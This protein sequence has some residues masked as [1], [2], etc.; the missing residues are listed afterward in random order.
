MGCSSSKA[1]QESSIE[2]KPALVEGAPK[3]A[4]PEPAAAVASAGVAV[5]KSR[6]ISWNDA[7]NDMI[8]STTQLK[9]A[10]VTLPLAAAAA[11]PRSSSCTHELLFH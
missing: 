3:V 2:A 9:S 4:E 10:H 11:A 6:K 1:V 5:N 8:A 7:P